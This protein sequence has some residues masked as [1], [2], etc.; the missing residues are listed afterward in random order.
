MLPQYAIQ[1]E[2]SSAEAFQ[3]VAP[4]QS[5]QP[6]ELGPL[7]LTRT[8]LPHPHPAQHPS[9]LTV[10]EHPPCPVVHTDY[11]PEDVVTTHLNMLTLL[12]V[13]H[14]I[15]P[16]HTVYSPD[17]GQEAS[18]TMPTMV[19]TTSE[20]ISAEDHGVSGDALVEGETRSAELEPVKSKGA[21]LED[22]V[23]ALTLSVLKNLEDE[24]EEDKG[25]DKPLPPNTH[26]TNNSQIIEG[27]N[28]Y[29]NPQTDPIVAP[30]RP[31]PVARDPV[32]QKTVAALVAQLPGFQPLA[33]AIYSSIDNEDVTPDYQEVTYDPGHVTLPTTNNTVDIVT[34][35][36]LTF[37]PGTEEHLVS[38][39]HNPIES[40]HSP[41]REPECM[42]GYTP[43]HIMDDS[44]TYM[45]EQTLPVLHGVPDDPAIVHSGAALLPT[46]DEDTDVFGGERGLSLP[47]FSHTDLNDSTDQSYVGD[48]M[49]AMAQGMADEVNIQIGYNSRNFKCF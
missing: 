17:V 1:I 42:G 9:T 44:Q 23:E 37:H 38:W 40:I 47:V 7:Y 11:H 6:D 45:G 28:V 20:H 3:S 39:L 32:L 49:L 15:E 34:T 4:S 26:L 33:S 35:D 41:L 18:F 2:G 14:H 36:P 29:Y 21:C 22:V 16:P 48:E 31:A 30:V 24:D 13:Q 12:D 27:E 43:G 25:E 8:V 46:V 10:E 19:T 5:H